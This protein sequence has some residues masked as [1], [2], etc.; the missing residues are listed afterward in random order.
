MWRAMTAVSFSLGLIAILAGCGGGY[1]TGGGGSSSG[2]TGSGTSGSGSGGGSSSGAMTISSISPTSATAGS[3]DTTLIVTGSNLDLVHS[4]GHQTTTVAVWSANGSQAAS[5]TTTVL[6]GTQLIAVVPAAL[7]A[8]P[9]TA[10]IFIQKWYFADD[11]PFATSNSLT[12]TV[13]STAST[14]TAAGSMTVARSSHSATLLAN[15]MVLVAGGANASGTLKS[16]ELYDPAKGTFAA[17]GDLAFPRQG[18]S[19]TLLPNGK[20][21]IAGGE[22]DVGPIATAELYDPGSGTFT[23]VGNMTSVRW[24]HTATLLAN[25]KVLLAGGAN[26]SDSQ[27]SAEVFDPVSNMFSPV[28]SMTT[29][30]MHHTATLLANG[31]VLLAGGW[32][33]YAPITTLNS[34]EL[35]DPATNSFGSVGNMSIAHWF[36]RSVL[37]PDG[38][39]LVVAGNKGLFSKA[40]IEAF[41]PVSGS[42]A[43]VGS[44][45][46]A[47]HSHTAT[48]LPNGK[49]LVTGGSYSFSGPDAPESIVLASSELYL[50]GSS[51][52]EAAPTL[53]SPRVGHT[54]TLLNDGRV[55]VVGGSGSGGNSLA[56]AEILDIN[57]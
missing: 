43:I 44:L 5:L 49:V 55:L 46:Q 21:L 39:V 26:N 48:L 54:A 32:S 34:A 30:R 53:I 1:A 18:H 15:G 22:D 17:T 12:F 24:S 56:S 14:S 31:N 50:P 36:H 13:T 10:Q 52:T 16:A 6:S 40:V 29:P 20:V 19:A 51:G 2:S 9:V 7:L 38:R 41:D 57:Q 3:G 4:G 27:D 23:S 45:T 25:G 35:F 33:S 42:F 37:L 8:T 47:R 11:S 28:S